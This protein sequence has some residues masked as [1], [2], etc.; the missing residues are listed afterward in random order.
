[1]LNDAKKKQINAEKQLLLAND[2]LVATATIAA[3]CH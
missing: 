3:D 1:M 2:V